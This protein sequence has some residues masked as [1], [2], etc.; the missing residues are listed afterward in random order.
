MGSAVGQEPAV[1]EKITSWVAEAAT[2]PV[3][4]KLTPNIT[5]ITAAARAAKRG[6]ANAISLINTLNSITQVNLDDFVPE[7]N[8]GGFSTHGGYCGPAVKPIALNMVQACAADPQLQVPLSGIGGI[9]SWQDAA[10]FISLGA[11]SVQVCTAIMHYGFRI[12]HNMLDGLNAYLD[13]KGFASVAELRG[14]AVPAL[15]NWEDLDLNSQ[16]IARINYDTCIGCNLCYVACEDGAYQSIDLVDPTGYPSGPRNDPSKPV[17]KI[18]EQ[19][20][21]GCNLCAIVC[22]VDGC[23]TMVSVENGK[24]KLTWSDYQAKL[25]RGEMKPIPAKS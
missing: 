24:P 11:T 23:I 8:V 5:D 15:K 2:I 9:A 20:C 12:V 22:P 21:V 16:R 19:D 17:P 3:I 1:T 14:R 25:A 6:G 4:V 13:A 18:R 10:E 7:P